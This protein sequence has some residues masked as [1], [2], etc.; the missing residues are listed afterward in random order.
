MVFVGATGEGLGEHDEWFQHG[1]EVWD[2]DLRVP[3]A[4]R[5]PGRIP[6]GARVEEPVELVDVVPTVLSY[7]G[8]GPLQGS[9]G[10]DLRHTVEGT[11]VARRFARSMVRLPPAEGEETPRRR[12]AIH[13][14]G[15]HFALPRDT[16]DV[17]PGEGAGW[18]WSEASLLRILEQ[19]RRLLPEEED[20]GALDDSHR[21]L[22]TT[23]GYRGGET[24]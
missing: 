20:A 16:V 15:V 18:E 8:R 23:L 7:A 24:R 11:G 5:F 12:V 2:H 17:V 9:T 1:A 6:A 21:D 19:V 4:L 22:L 14:P 13:F 3:L 10:L